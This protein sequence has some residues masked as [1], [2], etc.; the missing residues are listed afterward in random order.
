MIHLS[1]STSLLQLCFNKES[2]RKS[3]SFLARQ[4]LSRGF[5]QTTIWGILIVFP[6]YRYSVCCKDETS[7]NSRVVAGYTVFINTE[8]T[9][10]IV[11]IRCAGL[12]EVM[13]LN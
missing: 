12:S 8:C 13:S 11:K 10:K 5:M 1:T 7:T 3:L 4:G 9:V 6:F 2:A